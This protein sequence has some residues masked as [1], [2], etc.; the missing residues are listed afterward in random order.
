MELPERNFA[1]LGPLVP[2]A[3]SSKS[4]RKR[5]C[6]RF[7]L[8]SFMLVFIVIK[9]G[10]GLNHF[11]HKNFIHNAG[12][13]FD[14]SAEKVLDGKNNLPAERDVDEIF[15]PQNGL[16]LPVFAKLPKSAGEIRGWN[17]GRIN[18]CI[19]FFLLRLVCFHKDKISL[20]KSGKRRADFGDFLFHFHR[21]GVEMLFQLFEK[22]DVFLRKRDSLKKTS[23]LGAQKF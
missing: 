10:L 8:L 20:L 12:D 15:L 2:L 5:I 9:S 17:F 13:R 21:C 3:R 22:V 1:D 18:L 7:S 14:I 4:V 11:F 16:L 19:D 23:L 6:K